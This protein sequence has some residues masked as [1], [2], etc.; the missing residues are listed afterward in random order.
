VAT[1]WQ[2]HKQY[3]HME[4]DSYASL[5]YSANLPLFSGWHVPPP[6]RQKFLNR[7][8]EFKVTLTAY[9]HYRRD[10]PAT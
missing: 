7:R 4:Q 10:I 8:M 5:L 6:N 3:D 9:P 2:W 1:L